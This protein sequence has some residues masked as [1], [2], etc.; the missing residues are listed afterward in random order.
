MEPIIV[1]G[2]FKFGLKSVGKALYNHNL[3]ETTWKE[4]D[5][6]LDSMIKFKEICEKNDKNIPLKRFIEIDEI[7]EYNRIDCQVLFEI[8]EVLRNKYG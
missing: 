4:S 1:Q 5:S 8:V 6:G 3:I 7:I 2:I